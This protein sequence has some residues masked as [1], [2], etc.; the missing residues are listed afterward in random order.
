MRRKSAKL[1]ER[2]EFYR[3]SRGTTAPVEGADP[4][5]LRKQFVVDAVEDGDR[6]VDFVASTA[7]VDRYGDTI[8]VEGWQLANYRANPVILWAHDSYVPAIGRAHNVRTDAGALKMRVEFAT[9]KQNPLAES[10]YQLVKGGFIRTGSVG[11]MPMRWNYVD[12]DERG[13]GIDFLEQ[14]LYEFSICNIPAN[15]DATIQASLT[16]AARSSLMDLGRRTLLLAGAPDPM[17][18]L[19]NVNGKLRLTVPAEEIV[20]E[21]EGTAFQ[22]CDE[23]TDPAACEAAGGC[24]MKTAR[25][26]LVRARSKVVRLHKVN[27]LRHLV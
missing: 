20:I 14:E 1:I 6:A 8:A 22:P 27:A 2:D 17:L 3:T 23:C 12:N 4:I 7:S 25:E 13:F 9:E 26:A 19:R 16:D 11:F 18:M 24:Q 15:P 21:R 5:M 10:I